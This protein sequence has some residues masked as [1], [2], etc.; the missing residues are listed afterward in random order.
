MTKVAQPLRH[1]V[2]M[3]EVDFIRLTENGSRADRLEN[4]DE[5]KRLGLS[6]RVDLYNSYVDQ[7]N[8]ASADNDNFDKSHWQSKMAN[9]KRVMEGVLGQQRE[10]DAVPVDKT[11]TVGLPNPDY[12]LDIGMKPIVLDDAMLKRG[13]G[14]QVNL[15]NEYVDG[16]NK[17]AVARDMQMQTI[18][19]S[20]I[21]SLV[22][23][24]KIT[25]K[26][27]AADI[28]TGKVDSDF[29]GSVIDSGH[30]KQ[31]LIDAI[32]SGA[33]PETLARLK[34]AYNENKAT[35]D[36]KRNLDTA[37]GAPATYWPDV[38]AEQFPTTPEEAL[39]FNKL[40]AKERQLHTYV[41]P[42]D[43]KNYA[44]GEYDD[45]WL[46]GRDAAATQDASSKMAF[47][48]ARMDKLD[49]LSKKYGLPA[50]PAEQP[51]DDEFSDVTN[52]S[53][54]KDAKDET[55]A[56]FERPDMEIGGEARVLLPSEKE[57]REENELWDKYSLVQRGFGNGRNNPLYLEALAD[58]R[59]RYGPLRTLETAAPQRQSQVR[60]YEPVEGHNIFQ[61]NS[62]FQDEYDNR[63]FNF[64]Q[65]LM[66]GTSAHEFENNRSGLHPDHV[67]SRSR[68]KPTRI[69]PFRTD[70]QGFA[71]YNY[72]YGEGRQVMNRAIAH[73]STP[74]NNAKGFPS[75]GRL[76]SADYQLARR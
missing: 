76:D 49:E 28:D 12:K 68:S 34:L 29:V 11:I 41:N 66:N 24:S 43:K 37:E 45:Y 9:L 55:D 73:E 42:Y 30:A 25:N 10:D 44:L 8:L 56:K 58:E 4:T 57:I 22:A 16:F 15:Y 48:K 70:G 69:T 20:K 23:Q 50:L 2:V 51:Q 19:V 35:A 47:Y 65:Q 54:V 6:D 5:F 36:F 61:F 14:P 52:V 63:L 39:T 18:W 7:F 31:K 46:D 3:P 1:N 17:A 21:K 75:R 64:T 13:I 32:S 67:L 40:Q 26:T 53:E 59:R 33:S 62:N 38:A 60:G 72:I 27:G 74:Y 71:P